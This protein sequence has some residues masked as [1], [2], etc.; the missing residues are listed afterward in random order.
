MF[1]ALLLLCFCVFLSLKSGAV[2]EFETIVK[3]TQFNSSSRI[4]IDKEI[5]K[6]AERSEH[7]HGA[8]QVVVTGI[9]EVE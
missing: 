2:Q 9:E 1:N 7:G 4:V 5:L 8:G 3:D 6:G